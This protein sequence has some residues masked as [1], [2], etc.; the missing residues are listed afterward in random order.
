[1]ENVDNFERY[2]ARISVTRNWL[3]LSEFHALWR[4]SGLVPVCCTVGFLNIYASK[5]SFIFYYF[6]EN[7]EKK[8]LV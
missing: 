8:K 6:Q 5:F 1:M 7:L 3:N 2:L 4:C